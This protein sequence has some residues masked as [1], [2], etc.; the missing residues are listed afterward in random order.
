MSQR[1]FMTAMTHLSFHA[2]TLAARGNQ[3]QALQALHELLDHFEQAVT[4]PPQG[5]GQAMQQMA[6]NHQ[7]HVVAFTAPAYA[8]QPGLPTPWN[9]APS[10]PSHTPGQ[11]G[12]FGDPG[13]QNAFS[14]QIPADVAMQDKHLS[15]KNRDHGH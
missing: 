6:A 7:G 3:V 11:R 2:A 1:D 4:F 10:Q 9:A 5:N 13:A 15:P 12:Q 14:T 8:V